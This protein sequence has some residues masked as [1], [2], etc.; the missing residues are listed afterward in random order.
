MKGDH[1]GVIPI[2]L[3]DWFGRVSKVGS[4][5]GIPRITRLLEVAMEGVIMRNDHVWSYSSCKGKS[6]GSYE[7]VLVSKP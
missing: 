4:W 5:G 3:R 7:N 6:I 2:T 1:M